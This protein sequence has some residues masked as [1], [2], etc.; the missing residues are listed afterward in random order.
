MND[1]QNDP[2]LFEAFIK[3]SQYLV[4]L[5]TQQDIW[6]HLSKLV[7]TYFP[8]N[9]TA[10]ARRDQ[11]KGISIHSSSLGDELTSQYLLTEEI[12]NAITDVL[13]S[14]FLATLIVSAPAA[15]MTVFL[16]I[17]EEYKTCGVMLIGHQSTEPISSEL[18]NIYL[19]IAGLAGETSERLHNELELNRH[20]TQLEEI[21]KERTKELT[22]VK[23]QNEVILNSIGEGIYGLDTDGRI[24]FVNPSAVRMLGWKQE[25]LIG[26]DA[27]ATIHHS[28][29]DGG[30][31]SVEDC[32]VHRALK[33][34]SAKAVDDEYFFRKDGS[35]FPVEFMLTPI[36]EEVRGLRAVV[37]FRDI[38]ERKKA[39]EELRRSNHKI[40]EIL[41]SIQEDFYVIDSSWKFVFASRTFTSKIGKEPKD[42]VGHN[43][44]QMFPKHIGTEFEKNLMTVMEQKE[45]RRFEI[46]GKYTNAYYEMV[47][48]PSQEGILVLGS[49]ITKRKKAEDALK[50]YARELE[51]ANKEL[52]AF[53][54]SVS[55]DLKAPLRAMDGF[56]E[57]LIGDYKEKLDETGQDY[58]NR[59]RKASQTMSQLINDMLK[60]S[61]IIRTEI[62]FETVGISEMIKS[63]AKELQGSQP[64]RKVKFVIKPEVMVTADE[65]L[66]EIALK[67]LLENAWKFTTKRDAGVI[68]FGMTTQDG[69]TVYFIKDNGVGFD[70]TYKDKL[71]QPFQRLH[72]EKEFP[73]TGIGLAIVERIIR[74]HG[75]RIWAASEVGKGST[76]FFTFAGF[77]TGRNFTAEI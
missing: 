5:K 39:E 21:V 33:N 74:R 41:D 30:A 25:E 26:S 3:A 20:R 42:F 77:N 67:N 46:G 58:L 4:R 54:Y 72:N 37:V 73:G 32:S 16:P 71:F 38:S 24:N 61:R 62:Q 12:Q 45:I 13:D 18:L 52:E 44:W 8:A 50:S 28:H 43:I 68:E 2:K 31:C 15:S 48:F 59:I 60:L 17:V 35:R 64:E 56:S 6:E 14:G 69:E 7:M 1:F 47:V 10:F 76:F 66:L 27:N 70:M 65:R 19:A 9:W 53:S 36:E 11:G 63:I 57:I 23:H 55:H 75:G 29:S 22:R 49:D 51:T 34:G 40:A